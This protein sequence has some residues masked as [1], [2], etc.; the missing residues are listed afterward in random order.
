MLAVL[1]SPIV[2]WLRR[3]RVPAPAAATIALLLTIG[4]LVALGAA[5]NSPLRDLTRESPQS[6]TKARTTITE[7]A[8]PLMRMQRQLN[9]VSA[10][11]PA[12]TAP[13]AASPPATET[14]S[15][16]DAPPPASLLGGA[17][18]SSASMIAE[19]AGVLLLSLLILAGGDVWRK[20]MQDTAP[21]RRALRS[22]L[23]V[24]QKMRE[25]VARYLFVTM[26]INI[27]QGVL[28]GLATWWLALPSPI[29]WGALTFIAEFIPHLGGLVMVG[30]LAVIGLATLDGARAL[31][32]RSSRP[33][34]ISPSRFSRTTSGARSRMAA[35]WNSTRR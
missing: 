22:T 18:G 29:L 30:L 19:I 32:A 28:F 3:A 1:L 5:L 12:R 10:P 13:T 2:G 8:A 17:L 24:A 34:P 20:K 35:A 7:L 6:I 15:G 23:Q 11:A 26:L 27:G 31:L 16:S 21:S 4:T 14:K 9:D 33:A 25:V